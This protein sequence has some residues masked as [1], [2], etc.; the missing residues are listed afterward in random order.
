VEDWEASSIQIPTSLDTSAVQ[1]HN[2]SFRVVNT[3]TDL[4]VSKYPTMILPDHTDISDSDLDCISEESTEESPSGELDTSG[5]D[6]EHQKQSLDMAENEVSQF[7]RW[8]MT[9]RKRK[10]Q[11]S[12]TSHV[13]GERW[14]LD[15]FDPH[16]QNHKYQTDLRLTHRKTP[17][18]VSSLAFITA[19]K[20]ASVTLAS[21]SIHPK[22][23]KS[24]Q[25]TRWHDNQ[26]RESIDSILVDTMR[27]VDDST[28][29]R[30][31]Q[32][33]RIVEEIVSSEESY[34]RDMKTLI[35]VPSPQIL[36]CEML[37]RSRCILL[38]FRRMD[39]IAKP[40]IGHLHKSSLFMKIFS[41]SYKGC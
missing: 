18:T 17:S 1:Q 20:S 23:R 33:R 41:I 5:Q 14:I 2:V 28:W 15:D 34:I 38:C 27:T 40:Y 26:L 16:P 25:T 21:F 7:S 37:K 19:V 4:E 39:Q 22:S 3:G 12:S 6:L 11:R 10:M 9:L 30:S 32:R 13:S 31:I 36:I 8:L 29:A 35:T 24:L